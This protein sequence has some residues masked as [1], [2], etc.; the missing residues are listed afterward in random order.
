MD[1]HNPVAHGTLCSDCLHWK[2]H[3]YLISNGFDGSWS[4]QSW[5]GKGVT[6]Q[7]LEHQT[8]Q[9]T[10]ERSSLGCTQQIDYRWEFSGRG[11]TSEQPA[12]PGARGI[13]DGAGHLVGIEVGRPSTGRWSQRPF[14]M[15]LMTRRIDP[16]YQRANTFEDISRHYMHI[17]GACDTSLRRYWGGLAPADPQHEI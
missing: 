17:I 11:P 12:A 13:Y 5:T 7:A 15:K 6:G 2:C 1:P 9:Q 16:K 3:G 8:Y 10:S 4:E 14:P